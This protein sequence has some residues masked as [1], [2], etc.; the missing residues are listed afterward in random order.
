MQL[1]LTPR[2]LEEIIQA[3]ETNPKEPV[4]RFDTLHY[5][6]M[7]RQNNPECQL[8]EAGSDLDDIPF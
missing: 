3:L 6:K 1:H 2:Q 5:L 4:D 8:V 7:V